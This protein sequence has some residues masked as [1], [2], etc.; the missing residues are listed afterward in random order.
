MNIHDALKAIAWDRAE[1]FKYKF[2]AVRFDQTK[3]LK[4][5]AEFLNVVNK[6]TMNPYLRWEKTAEYKALVTLMLQART[7]DDLQEIY[8][9]VIQNAKTGDDKAVKL[10]LALTREI[11]T[12]AKLALKN[13]EHQ[14]EDEEDNDDLIV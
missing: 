2:P 10:F 7:A 11:D 9:V 8:T 3:E 6:K 4:T 5:Q 14:E 13:F 12:H 1:Y